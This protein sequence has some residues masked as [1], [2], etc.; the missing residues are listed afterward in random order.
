VRND[1][2]LLDREVLAQVGIILA[3][4]SSIVTRH[5]LWERCACQERSCHSTPDSESQMR[6]SAEPTFPPEIL[7]ELFDKLHSTTALLSFG[8][9]CRRALIKTRHILFSNLEF[10]K[11]KDF[12]QF[13]ELVDVPW[14]SFTLAV[15]EIHLSDL[16]YPDHDHKYRDQ[17][18]STRIASNLCNV[19][20][21]SIF[22]HRLCIYKWDIIP[23]SVLDV[24]LKLKIHDLQLD[25]LGESTAK[26]MVMLFHRLPS[27]K[28]LAFRRL[29]YV[30]S[31]LSQHLSI[32]RRPLHFRM[33]DNHSLAF[34][35]DVLDPSVNPDLDVTVHTF[36]IRDPS[37]PDYE[38][39]NPLTWRFLQHIGHAIERLLI[40]FQDPHIP[41]ELGK[42]SFVKYMLSELV[43]FNLR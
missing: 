1:Y 42:L 4:G 5:V 29:Q 11:N 6:V 39:C 3:H 19:K 34:L 26:D 32:F 22:V 24:I 18:D 23:R 9:V 31:D 35:K 40:T 28:T 12:D 33:L 10:T 16:F 17:I 30:Q 20:S 13:L 8:L 21:L 25:G 37:P 27:I 14:T 2:Q 36:H 41:F 15:K 43:N 7:E 38:A